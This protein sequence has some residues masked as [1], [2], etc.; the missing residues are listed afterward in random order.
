MCA[1]PRPFSSAERSRKALITSTFPYASRPLRIHQAVDALQA[2]I[3]ARFLRLAGREARF[4]CAADCH[5][6]E[7]QRC[8][9][10]NGV[11]PET[12]AIRYSDEHREDFR[13]LH[14]EF[15]QF[16]PT[17]SSAN[18]E[19]S[20]FV[21]N[22]L[23]E[24]GYLYE[25]EV[26]LGYCPTCRRFLPIRFDR[27]RCPGCGIDV[28]TPGP[29][30]V[31]GGFGRLAEPA[32][33]RCPDCGRDTVIKLSRHYFFRLSEFSGR[34]S[35][36]AEACGLQT[37]VRRWVAERLRDG[38]DDWCVSRDAPYFGFPVPGELKKFLC[39][40][41]DAPLGYLTGADRDWHWGA[42]EIIQ[43]VRRDTVAFHALF[44]PA[45]LMG[46]DFGLPD[47]IV[48]QGPVSLEG[49]PVGSG[50]RAGL[51]IRQLVREVD[52]ECLRYAMASR[53]GPGLDEIELGPAAFSEAVQGDL[54]GRIL[55]FLRRALERP[56]ET[57]PVPIP[58]ELIG[59]YAAVGSA[60]AGLDLR[61]A[62]AAVLSLVESAGDTGALQPWAPAFCRDLAILLSPVLPGLCRRV[63]ALY[64]AGRAWSW[65]DLGARFDGRVSGTGESLAGRLSG[66]GR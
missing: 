18:H 6:T 17:H 30:R 49:R 52:P 25:R 7:V 34:L 15:D 12:L 36:W 47:R 44:W 28:E 19:L 46:A 54:G 8:A 57:A 24:K 60:Y 11:D 21:F 45:V 61:G 22:R 40:W 1:V 14:I 41:L 39:V 55:R 43:F 27:G 2:D 42:G 56:G 37:E 9:A 48:T 5:G 58:A 62:M 59:A 65:D 16:A 38:L 51:E 10:D 35:S 26:P 64:G 4:I 23:R 33:A 31:C 29:C 50:Q 66:P 20:V 3:Y 13:S 32:E 53:M 63:E